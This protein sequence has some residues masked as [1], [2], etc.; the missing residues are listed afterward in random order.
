METLFKLRWRDLV[1]GTVHQ[2]PA[3]S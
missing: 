1:D 2:A 3:S